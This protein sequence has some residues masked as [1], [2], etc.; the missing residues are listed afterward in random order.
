MCNI[1]ITPIFWGR[2]AVGLAVHLIFAIFFGMASFFTYSHGVIT[3][4]AEVTHRPNNLI[5]IQVQFDFIKL[6]NFYKNQYGL[7]QLVSLSPTDFGILYQEVVKLFNRKL[8]VK[9]QGKVLQLNAR[10]PSEKQVF[11]LLKQAF[12][13]Q[14]IPVQQQFVPYT[15]STRRYYQQFHFDIKLPSSYTKNEIFKTLALQ[16]P[17]ELGDINVTFTQT[18]NFEVHQGDVWK[19]KGD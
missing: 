16:F 8:S 3:T 15:Y 7:Q 4:T 5:E 1:K 13:H 6:L 9:H 2:I 10:F 18:N 14:Q 19:L 12:L 11:D 17:T